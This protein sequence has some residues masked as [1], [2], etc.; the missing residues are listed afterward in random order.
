MLKNLLV[1]ILVVLLILLINP[2]MFWMPSMMQMTALALTAGLIFVWAGFVL[3]ERADDEREQANRTAS[4]RFAYIASALVLTLA[5][6]VQ[7]ISHA[8]DPW[9]VYALLAMIVAKQ[10]SREYVDRRN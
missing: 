8:I 6:L 4:G 2:F 3:T 1:V 7:G 10:A 9:I 5:L